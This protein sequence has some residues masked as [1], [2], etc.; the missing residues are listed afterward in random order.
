MSSITDCILPKTCRYAWSN[1]DSSATKVAKISAAKVIESLRFVGSS[2]ECVPVML[3]VGILGSG[4]HIASRFME[5]F[6]GC[7]AFSAK[8]FIT[9]LNKWE[10]E[11]DYTI[12][13]SFADLLGIPKPP[14]NEV[15]S[16]EFVDSAANNATVSEV[17]MDFSLGMIQKTIQGS[18]LV[19]VENIAGDDI[20]CLYR[21]IA[22][23]RGRFPISYGV[24]IAVMSSI[25]YV[26]MS[27]I[28]SSG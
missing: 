1:H 28:R 3:S 23:A 9:E 27:A 7:E 13:S 19:K 14:T 16:A 15:F 26:F 18:R 4:L 2:I 22:I 6:T 17:C 12:N 24:K 5:A 21:K 11:V 25:M 20:T 10:G 8:R